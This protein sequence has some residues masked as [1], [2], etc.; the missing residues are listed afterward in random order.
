MHAE[1]YSIGP[2]AK[3]AL[4][5][6]DRKTLAVGTTSVRTIEHYLSFPDSEPE[7]QPSG[8]PTCSFVLLTPSRCGSLLT[9]TSIC[10]LDLALSGLRSF[11]Q[12]KEDDIDTQGNLRPSRCLGI[13]ILQLWRCNADLVTGSELNLQST[14]SQHQPRF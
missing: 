9:R 8:K 4:L 3:N 12:A 13:P 10:G 1:E 2:K 6:N 5:A 14:S 7:K 11:R